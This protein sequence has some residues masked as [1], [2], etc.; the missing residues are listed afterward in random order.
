MQREEESISIIN[1]HQ[2]STSYNQDSTASFIEMELLS[3][4]AESQTADGLKGPFEDQLVKE[5]SALKNEIKNLQS[6]ILK[7]KHC[8]VPSNPA[9][10]PQYQQ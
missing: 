6:T 2:D 8:I 1:T 4:V 9:P 10:Y 7:L 5:N 3:S